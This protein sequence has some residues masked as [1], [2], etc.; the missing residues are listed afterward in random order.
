MP[1]YR[2]ILDGSDVTLL[3]GA[4]LDGLADGALVVGSATNFST[5][6]K[7]L[8]TPMIEAAFAGTT[9]AGAQI[10]CWWIKST[11]GTKFETSDVVPTRAPDFVFS[12]LPKTGANTQ[13][14]AAQGPDMSPYVEIPSCQAK[15]AMRPN[16]TG[17]NFA[18]GTGSLVWVRLHTIGTV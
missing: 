12:V 11:D 10:E 2:N 17:S 13:V 4:N 9:T 16:G 14:L 1:N 5:D 8:G 6:G 15:L 18:S 3:T 7:I